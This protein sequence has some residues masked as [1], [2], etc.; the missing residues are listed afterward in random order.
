VLRG[1]QWKAFTVQPFM[2]RE[3]CGVVAIDHQ[4]I[5]LFGG[6]GEAGVL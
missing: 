5:L 1:S 2:P 4:S 3:K 6:I